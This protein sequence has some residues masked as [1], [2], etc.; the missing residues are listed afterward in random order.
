MNFFKGSVKGLRTT[1]DRFG[2]TLVVRRNQIFRYPD[3]DFK[4]QVPKGEVPRNPRSR[5]P[6]PHTYR[7]G[8]DDFGFGVGAL[9]FRGFRVW[10]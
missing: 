9:G 10:L 4:Y 3:P 1:F 6:K 5:A 8:G 7:D 2:Y